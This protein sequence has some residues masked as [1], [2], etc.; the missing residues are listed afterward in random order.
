MESF[1][2]EF[3]VYASLEKGLSPNTIESYR[4]DLRGYIAFLKKKH[5]T[6]LDSITDSDIAAYLA[7][8]AKKFSSKSMARK[9]SSIRNFHIFLVRENLTTNQPA[10]NLITPKLEKKLPDVLEVDEINRMFELLEAATKISDDSDK[11]KQTKAL[12][13]RD[14]CILEVMYGAGLR[15][16]ETISLNVT[17]I[18]FE[19]EFIRC[20]GKGSKYR[21][22]PIISEAL[23][24]LKEYIEDSR[25]LIASTKVNSALFLNVRGGRLSRTSCWKIIKKAGARAGIEK[26]ITPHTIRHSF[27]THLLEN[28]ADL[29]SVQEL[30]GHA[31]ISTTQ[32][33]THISR[34]HLHEVYDKFHPMASVEE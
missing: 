18:E 32:I 11:L 17:D 28:G 22:V 29:R 21:I 16:S 3:L 1:L 6:G 25:P 14:L 24:V 27:A 12:A 34:K 10:V 5:I 8:L 19:S 13:R 26:L 4:C 31:S 15:I 20:K 33:Y 30:L 2:D 9:I 23:A 7:H